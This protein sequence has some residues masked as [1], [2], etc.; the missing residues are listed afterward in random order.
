MFN[1]NDSLR[2]FLYDR[3][4]DMRKSFHTLSGIVTNVMG[5]DPYDGDVY[6]FINRARNRIKLLHWESGGMVLYSK[7]LEEGTFARLRA[8]DDDAVY[9]GIEWRDLVMIVEGIVEDRGSRRKRL[10]SLRNSRPELRSNV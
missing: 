3:P 5:R 8:F 9:E 7:L 10:R 4:T 1:L 2:Y 6:I